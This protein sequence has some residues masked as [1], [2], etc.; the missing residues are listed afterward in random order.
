MFDNR[1]FE[2]YTAF[3]RFQLGFVENRQGHFFPIHFQLRK[4]FNVLV[5]QQHYNIPLVIL[6]V[7]KVVKVVT[8]EVLQV[9]L[10]NST[11]HEIWLHSI[12]KSKI[13]QGRFHF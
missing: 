1:L 7:R 6:K 2:R 9:S 11:A 3:Y 8:I 10:Y 5:L 12:A 4:F 13:E